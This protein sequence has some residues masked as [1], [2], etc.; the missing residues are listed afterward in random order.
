MHAACGLPLREQRQLDA[1][2]SHTSTARR[3]TENFPAQHHLLAHRRNH[4]LHPA[5]KRLATFARERLGVHANH[6]VLTLPPNHSPLVS[7]APARTFVKRACLGSVDATHVWV[8]P[9]EGAPL[10]CA[11]AR[12]MA[13][14][15][16]VPRVLLF[17]AELPMAWFF[18]TISFY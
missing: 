15:A 14:L 13:L 11:R 5:A 12:R 18:C 4:V 1:R 7:A 2:S 8:P 3:P 10:H 9:N 17:C 6:N 16:H